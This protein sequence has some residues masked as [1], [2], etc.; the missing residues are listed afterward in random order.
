MPAGQ[1]ARHA[2]VQSRGGGRAP[3]HRA[4]RQRRCR[5]GGHQSASAAPANGGT[6]TYRDINIPT[7]IDPLIAPTI[8]G[9][10]GG[11]PNL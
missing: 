5:L 3:G 9:G 2:T 1:Q 8:G 7:C 4:D 11:L 6:I 10:P